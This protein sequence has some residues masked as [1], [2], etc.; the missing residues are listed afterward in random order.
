I[1]SKKILLVAAA[2]LAAAVLAVF[3]GSWLV[4]SYYFKQGFN[5]FQKGNG[6]K[7]TS[8][9]NKSL[10]FSPKKPEPH[11]YLG[12]I[13]LGKATPGADLFY[14]AADYPAAAAHFEKAIAFGLSGKNKDLYSF[15][16]NDAGFS[17]WMMK[18]KDRADEK[19]LRLIEVSPDKSFVARYFVAFDY[20]N[21]LNKPKESLDILLPA[22]NVAVLDLHKTNLFRVYALLARLY[23][24]FDDAV[25][26]EK[27][28]KSAIENSS[29]METDIQVAYAIL[30]AFYGKEKNFE[31]AEAEIKKAVS[32]GMSPDGG[33]CALANSYFIGKNYAKA[34][35][36]AKSA[37]RKA[38]SYERSIC[39]SA[40]GQSYFAM[41]KTAESKKY[42]QEYLDLTDTFS[43][44]NIFMMRNRRQFE[45]EL[46]KL[47]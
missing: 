32:A 3:A 37:G 44:K 5:E 15:A 31:L 18:N 40:L 45:S 41:G 38:S 34:V 19:F 6:D 4:S 22:P 33:K 9:F 30:S 13:A 43:E 21:R 20:F 36:I 39:L 46:Q 11:F 47:K 10:K 25:N 2:I 35:E 42:F 28:A 12:K 17:Y 23:S 1:K 7:A 27:Y 16:L 29:G 26:A 8:F 14:S 24:Y